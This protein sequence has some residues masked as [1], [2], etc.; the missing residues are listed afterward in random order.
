MTKELFEKYL[1]Y[2]DTFRDSEGRLGKMLELKLNH[3]LRVVANA[4]LIEAGE[5]FDEDERRAAV[6]AALLHDTGRYEQLTRFNSFNDA[7]TIDHAV[8][9]RDLVRDFGWLDGRAD[10]QA[11]LDAILFHNRKELPTGL[12]RVTEA[13]AKTVRD[14]DK[15]DIFRILED[16]VET[17]DWRTDSRA[18]WNLSI[19]KAPNPKVLETIRKGE[20][21]DYADIRSLADFVLIQVGWIR[22]GLYYPSSRFLA[23]DRGHLEFR[24]RFLAELGAGP[25]ADEL[26]QLADV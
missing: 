6:D 4:G 25:E 22:S 16:L 8:L 9:S 18:F 23:Q 15:L 11:I 1:A 2:V 5:D 26:C 20:S 24:R 10:R 14:A 3:T 13:A 19:D 7:T 21:V 17:T 12:D